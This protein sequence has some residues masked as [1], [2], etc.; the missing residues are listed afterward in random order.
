MAQAM[1][2]VKDLSTDKDFNM[3]VSGPEILIKEDGSIDVDSIKK[4]IE[5]MPRSH[6]GSHGGLEF[7]G[8]ILQGK[9]Q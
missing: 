2:T 5:G 7:V 8:L 9:P 6:G 3:S 4:F 1:I